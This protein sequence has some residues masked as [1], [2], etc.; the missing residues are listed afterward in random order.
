MIKKDEYQCSVCDGIFKKGWTEEEAIQELKDEY[1]NIPD[2]EPLSI[3]CDDCYKD[4]MK[5]RKI[6]VFW[7]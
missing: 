1:G 4:Y 3:V 6:K 7:L 2:N 5:E